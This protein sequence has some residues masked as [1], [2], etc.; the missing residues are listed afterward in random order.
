MARITFT[1]FAAILSVCAEAA[2]NFASDD[3]IGEL[4]Y[5]TVSY[6]DTLPHIAK[7]FSMGLTEVEI[8]NN[9]IQ[10]WLPGTGA[11]VLLPSKYILPGGGRNGIVINIPEMRIYYYHEDE[12]YT[13]PIGVGREGWTIP[14]KSGTIIGRHKEPSWY[15]PESIRKEHAAEGDPLPKV[16]PPGP[17]NPLGKFALRLS[18]PGYLIHGTNK[19]YGIGMRVSHG[20]IRMYPGDIEELYRVTTVG[21]PFRIINEPVKLGLQGNRI[22]L[23]VHPHM[24]EDA[25]PQEQLEHK[26]Q[27]RINALT[28]GRH[29]SLYW[30]IISHSLRHPSGVPTAIGLTLDAS[31][32]GKLPETPTSL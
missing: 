28:S 20:C 32:S 2:S 6:N 17:D 5:V 9:H 12:I 31:S 3:I 7:S 13:W 11:K 14:Y 16:V 18:L 21:T 15:P 24:S 25:I 23:E 22:Y 8:A 4:S 29:M 26:L 27:K 19:D 30:D 1:I 10:R